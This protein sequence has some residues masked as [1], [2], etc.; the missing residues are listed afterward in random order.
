MITAYTEEPNLEL[1]ATMHDI[2][3]YAFSVKLTLRTVDRHIPAAH[4]TQGVCLQRP[5]M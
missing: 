3:M 5:I 2:L 1:G 4:L